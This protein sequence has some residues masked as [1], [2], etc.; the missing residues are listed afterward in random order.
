MFYLGDCPVEAQ[1]EGYELVPLFK[2]KIEGDKMV[3]DDKKGIVFENAGHPILVKASFIPY[4]AKLKR[5]LEDLKTQLAAKTAFKSFVSIYRSSQ[6]KRKK[7]EYIYFLRSGKYGD[8]LALDLGS[9]EIG[10]DNALVSIYQTACGK[11]SSAIKVKSFTVKGDLT[12]GGN[13][14]L[15]EIKYTDLDNGEVLRFFALGKQW[16]GLN[17]PK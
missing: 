11:G 8:E 2:P 13:V 3:V 7:G 16:L 6:H 1:A 14:A 15:K 9:P 5:E 10:E 12:L 4:V 17:A